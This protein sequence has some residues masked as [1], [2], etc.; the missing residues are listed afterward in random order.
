[1]LS[2]LAEVMAGFRKKTLR[3]LYF[4]YFQATA[5]ARH[6]G[7]FRSVPLKSYGDPA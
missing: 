4:E 7:L 2:R 6:L 5:V 1:M 3:I